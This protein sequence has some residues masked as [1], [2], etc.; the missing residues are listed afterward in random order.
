MPTVRDLILR[1]I[2]V[3][4]NTATDLLYE[5]IGGP[6]ALTATMRRY[7]LETIT[8]QSTAADWFRAERAAGDELQFHLRGPTVLGLSSPRDMGRR[9]EKIIVG[10][11]VSRSA[12]GTMLQILQ[13]QVYSSRIPR[14]IPIGKTAHKTGDAL[15]Y[16]ANDVGMIQTTSKHVV[17][18]VFTEQHNGAP[19]TLEDA[20][21]RIAEEVYHY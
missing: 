14:Y 12:S 8:G 18:S 2:D 1:M 21:G 10:D 13:R 7:G 17:F 11:A 5:R 16:I 4:D 3:S 20:I 6:P 9:I 19:S 15:P